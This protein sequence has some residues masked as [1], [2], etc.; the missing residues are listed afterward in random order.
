[1]F[2]PGPNICTEQTSV[3]ALIRCT[4]HDKLLTKTT[5][6]RLLLLS[7]AHDRFSLHLSVYTYPQFLMVYLSATGGMEPKCLRFVQF[8]ALLPHS[9]SQK[10]PLPLP[11]LVR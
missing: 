11:S 2:L 4:C 5:A 6:L 1:M 3:C 9:S 7:C 10:A 8:L